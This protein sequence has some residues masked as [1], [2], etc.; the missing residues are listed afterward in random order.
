MS[1]TVLVLGASGNFGARM[2]E[3]FAA[4]GWKVRRYRR[5]TDMAAAAKGADLIVNGLNP[6]M[7][8]NWAQLIPAKV[9]FKTGLGAP[10][11][12]V[13]PLGQL[14]IIGSMLPSGCPLASS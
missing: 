13:G 4:A 2:A 10:L 11:V 8:H 12:I 3:A 5:G 9:V 1:G 14:G 6:P 7:Y